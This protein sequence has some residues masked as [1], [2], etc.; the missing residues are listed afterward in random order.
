MIQVVK[1]GS[2][3][4]FEKHPMQMQRMLLPFLSTILKE[5]NRR[6]LL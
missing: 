6:A 3:K 2:L 5:N 4:I 1:Y